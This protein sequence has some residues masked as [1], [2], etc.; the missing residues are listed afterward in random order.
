MNISGKHA[1]PNFCFSPENAKKQ[2]ARDAKTYQNRFTCYST[3]QMV[4]FGTQFIFRT[5]RKR[6]RAIN[7]HNSTVIVV[8]RVYWDSLNW[9]LHHQNKKC[10]R[11]QFYDKL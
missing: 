3:A 9:I 2:N 10:V 8:N 5:M 7:T 4:R 11:L 1:F 6:V